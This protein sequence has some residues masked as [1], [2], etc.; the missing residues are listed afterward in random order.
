MLFY[1]IL[2]TE[3]MRLSVLVFLILMLSTSIFFAQN[4]ET[5]VCIIGGGA[6]GVSAAIQS[7]RLGAKTVLIEETPW[8]GGMLTAA[9]VSCT[10]GNHWMPSGIWAE[11]RQKLYDYY[12]GPKEVA[13][14]WVSLTQFEPHIGAKIWADLAAAEPNLTVLISTKFK[15]VSRTKNNEKWMINVVETRHALSLRRTGGKPTQS[16]ES[17]IVVDATELGD[18]AKM[19]G[20]KYRIGTD[21]PAETIGEEGVALKQSDIIQD[22]TFAA[23]LKNYGKNNAPLVKKPANYDA[24][25]FTCSCAE[26]CPEKK[27]IVDAQKMLDYGKLPNGKYMINWPKHGNDHYANVIDANEKDRQKAFKLA[28]EKTLAF[29]YFI[30]NDLG[31]KNLGLADDEFPTPD[32]LPFIPYHRESRRIQGLTTMS[33]G[34]IS[35][36]FNYDLYRTGIAVGDYPIDHHHAEYPTTVPVGNFPK[37]PS[38]NVPLGA[39]I[40]KNTPNFIVAEKSISV[41]N[42]VNGTTRLQPIVLLIGQAAGVLAAVSAKEKMSPKDVSIRKIQGI[43]LKNKA[44]LMPY[45]D[46]KPD[47]PHFEAIQRIGATG[48][49][50]GVGEPHL[51]ANRTWFYP[52]STVSQN[53]FFVNLSIFDGDSLKAK[54]TDVD[55]PLST[56]LA[57]A[58]IRLIMANTGFNMEKIASDWTKWGLKNYD[59]KRPITKGELAVLLDATFNPF[60]KEVDFMGNIKK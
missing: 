11:W 43:L 45:F 15:K 56:E 21:N 38:F 16:I 54:E 55:K 58:I 26:K 8:L 29:V 27:G 5:D 20:V 30:Q 50:R 52:D 47:N 24:S 7:A 19:V 37:V 34:H 31:F 46:V 10:D 28:K 2:K 4:L 6:S 33:L 25:L 59:L 36:P 51:W 39:L 14:G 41:S 35:T 23:T 22:L 53:D 1:P 40:P 13:T 9:G 48:L 42:V 17:Q 18:V 32:R 44:Y 3:F 12:G 49:L 60:E 57:I